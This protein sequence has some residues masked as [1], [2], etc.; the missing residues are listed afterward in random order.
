MYK[1]S[2]SALALL[3]ACTASWGAD[4]WT[5][6]NLAI[7]DR[8]ILPRYQQLAVAGSALEQQVHA[9]CQEPNADTLNGAREGF[10][11]AMDAWQGIQHIRFGPVELFLRHSRY[12]LWPDKH[13]TGDK[14]IRKL[15][16]AEDTVLLKADNFR[17]AS[18][19]IQGL[20]ALERL[21]FAQSAE[22][23]AFG[24][25]GEPSYRCRLAEAIGVNVAEMGR[26]LVSD[27][28]EGYRNEILTAEAG[29]DSFEASQEV[30]A[31]LL[32]N[33]HTQLQAIVDQ[34]L[35]RPPRGRPEADAPRLRP[36]S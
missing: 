10:H 26:G 20:S 7:T 16:A 12:E 22:P 27:W 11:Q 25:P 8:H 14:Q 9:L 35:L 21:L 3:C 2:L 4:R 36:P 17:H 18:V 1:R 13:S 23:Q 34:K 33:L 32:N 30:S 5:D 15:L 31:K 28:R 29:N 19:A 24:H 6:I